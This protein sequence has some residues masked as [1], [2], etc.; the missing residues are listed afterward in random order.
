LLAGDRFLSVNGRSVEYSVALIP[1]LQERPD[2]LSIEFER[3]GEVLQADIAPLYTDGGAELG[4]YFQ[5]LQYR[6]PRLSPFAALAKGAR[7]MWKTLAISVKSLALLFKGIDLTKAVSGPVRITYMLGDVATAGFTESFGDGVRNLA[8]FL[9]LISVALC[10]M[11]LLPLPILD[12]GLIL[13][14]VVEIIK[15]S[16]IHPKAIAAFQTV[17]VV[18]I[19]GLMV[20]AVF[21]D[22]L[23]LLHN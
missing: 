8:N 17:G 5:S 11:N 14:F 9:C 4:V 15:G 1:I 23:Y 12:G 18:L 19:C 20:F 21:G 16:P 10:V 2:T 13:L 3:G 7:E 22:V 6:T